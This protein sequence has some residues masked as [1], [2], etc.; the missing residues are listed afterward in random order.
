MFDGNVGQGSK[1]T[2]LPVAE[3]PCK[4]IRLE[5]MNR[6]AY[7]MCLQ[8]SPEICSIAGSDKGKAAAYCLQTCL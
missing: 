2:K 7:C 3:T 8:I 5:D 6:T 4:E 1:G